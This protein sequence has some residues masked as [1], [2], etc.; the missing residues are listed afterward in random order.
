MSKVNERRMMYAKTLTENGVDLTMNYFSQ[1]YSKKDI[2]YKWCEIFKFKS[3][4]LSRTVAQQF[5]YSAQ[6]GY[7]LLNK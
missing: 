1:P 7:K 6:L 3:S 4:N 5:Y 2:I